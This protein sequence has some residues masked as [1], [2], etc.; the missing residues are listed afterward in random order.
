MIEITPVLLEGQRFLGV[1]MYLPKC[2]MHLL[3]NMKV[4]ILD[5]YFDLDVLEKKCP[6]P[7]I[8]CASI[9]F[10]TILSQKISKVSD[11]AYEYGMIAG[12]NVK[13]AIACVFLQKETS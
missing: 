7:M 3:L 5:S 8:Q 11:K 4:L 13:E 2:T 1:V 12:M 9:R 10:D 6:V